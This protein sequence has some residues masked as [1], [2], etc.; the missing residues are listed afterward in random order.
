[1]VVPL[2]SSSRRK[3]WSSLMAPLIVAIVVL[4]EI[5]FLGRLDFAVVEN[6]TTSFYF[7][8]SSSSNPSISI[9]HLVDVD[10]DIDVV[11]ESWRCEEWLEREDNVTYSRDFRSDPI[12]VSGTDQDWNSCSVGCKFG[13]IDNKIPDATFGLPENSATASVLRSME[14]SHYYA[15]NNIDLAR[16]RGFKIIMTTSLSSDVPVGYFSWAEYDIM[17]AVRPKTTDALAAAFISNCGARNFRLQALEML[18]KLD[19]KIDSYGSC[20]RN[21]DGRVDKV[22]TLKNYKF[23]LAFENSN[24]EDYVTEK[25]FQ[26]LVAGAIPVVVGAPNIQDFAPSNNSVLHI[27]EL[28]DVLSVAK[29]MKYLA[30]NSDAFN[31]SIRWK[32]E[33]PSDSFKA[34]VDMAAV[35]SSCRLCI[36]LATKIQEND[37]KTERFQ[38]RPCKCPSSR[39]NIY[40]LY[41]R[42]RGRFKMESIYLGY[43]NLTLEALESSVL[44]KFKSLG[45]IPIWK[46]ERPESIRGDVLK[47]YRIYPVGITQRQ[48]LY[49]FK[50][51]SDDDLKRYVEDHPC[52][53][54]E[55]VFV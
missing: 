55:V 36:H 12:L 45:H 30:T 14:S 54:L 4:G 6:W 7:P 31:K 48:A 1:M 37:E 42:E 41:V 32:Y 20:H 33:G 27:K 21:H 2:S 17:A 3:R 25:F 49:S 28:S 13:F 23:S 11:E 8:T 29:T 26:S 52:L 15:E 38:K 50:F 19:I 51:S 34:L 5:A 44:K 39:G 24:E 53:K 18:E 16:R 40:H 10:N 35:H 22:D 47:I 43:W 46:K 9:E